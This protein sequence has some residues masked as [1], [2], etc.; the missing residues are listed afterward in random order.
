MSHNW[1]H[2]YENKIYQKGFP[3]ISPVTGW[4]RLRTFAI[5]PYFRCSWFYAKSLP[6]QLDGPVS[7]KKKK[8]SFSL[9]PI[10]CYLWDWRSQWYPQ[11]QPLIVWVFTEADFSSAQSFL[12]SILLGVCEGWSPEAKILDYVDT[13]MVKRKYTLFQFSGFIYQVI[14]KNHLVLQTR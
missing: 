14:I 7:L 10:S 9:N 6:R 5:A 2:A 12:T 4:W 1:K 11:A 3:L 13:V 8:R